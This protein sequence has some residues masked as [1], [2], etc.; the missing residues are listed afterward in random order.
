MK[1]KTPREYAIKHKLIHKAFEK[2]PDVL[3]IDDVARDR[4][5]CAK[6]LRGAV[7]MDTSEGP[8]GCAALGLVYPGW[9]L[10]KYVGTQSSKSL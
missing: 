7:H 4:N 1:P 5:V 3:S 6:R 10:E 9:R 2:D 8:Q